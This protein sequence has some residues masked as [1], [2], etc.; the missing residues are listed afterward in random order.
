MNFEKLYDIIEDKNPSL[1]T[2]SVVKHLTP[3][4]FKKALKLAYD[5][6]YK[7]GKDSTPVFENLFGKSIFDKS[8]R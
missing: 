1:K 3:N 5:Q 6:G 4:N 8:N 7:E 2:D